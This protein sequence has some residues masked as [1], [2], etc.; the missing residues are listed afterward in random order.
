MPCHKNEIEIRN[1]KTENKSRQNVSEVGYFE[2]LVTVTV[3]F[4]KEGK[5]FEFES[6]ALPEYTPSFTS[7]TINSLTV[8]VSWKCDLI[9]VCFNYTRHQSANFKDN[10]VLYSDATQ[11]AEPT[12]VL[13]EDSSDLA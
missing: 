7:Y 11:T 6:Q 5:P 12:R 4:T 2:T 8:A 10:G 1:I 9:H 3:A 13:S